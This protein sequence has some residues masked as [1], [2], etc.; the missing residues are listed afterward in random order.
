MS[1]ANPKAHFSF[2][3]RTCDASSEACS[4]D[5]KRVLDEDELHP[6]HRGVEFSDNENSR[7]EQNALAG[8]ALS[9][10]DLPRY[11][12][13]ASRWPRCSPYATFIITPTSRVRRIR[14]TDNCFRASRGGMRGPG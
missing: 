2:R 5:L 4:A 8:V 14:A 9:S 10:I 6:A 1:P 3:L 11:F 12:A 13:T 7:S